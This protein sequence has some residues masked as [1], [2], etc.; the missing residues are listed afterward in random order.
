MFAAASLLAPILRGSVAD[1][2]A[3]PDRLVAR[4]IAPFVGR[5]GV[6]H[7]LD[8]ARSLRVEEVEELDLG[9]INVPT[10]VVWGEADPWIDRNIPTRLVHAIPNLRL[11]RLPH[12]GRL[13][14]EEA[15][16]ELTR[17]I[18]EHVASLAPSGDVPMAAAK[19]PAR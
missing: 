9:L 8:L 6:P 10:L 16:E 19:I 5:D 18:V 7:L 4:Y 13:A 17:L 14:P 12:V 15:P 2:A 1:P 11:V 3:M